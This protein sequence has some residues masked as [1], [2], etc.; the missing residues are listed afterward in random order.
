MGY[1]TAGSSNFELQLSSVL[2]PYHP[3]QVGKLVQLIKF[4]TSFKFQVEH[5][6]VT[7]NIVA[8]SLSYFFESE[9]PKEYPFQESSG[10]DS[11]PITVSL[12]SSLPVALQDIRAH[13][14]EDLKI[15]QIMK[16]KTLPP[17]FKVNRKT[18]MHVTPSQTLGRV[19]LPKNLIDMVFK[20]YH[21]LPI[22]A[23]MGMTKTYASMMAKF[24]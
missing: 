22:S 1:Q 16:F 9:D 8:D 19:V 12:L 3:R 18:L 7:D 10:S 6:K 4:I 21:E 17:N 13:Q 5:T 15:S 20:F 23:H 2:A 11:T 24:F 14:I